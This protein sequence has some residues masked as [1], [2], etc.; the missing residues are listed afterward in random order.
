MLIY[1]PTFDLHHCI[2]RLLQ[3]MNNCTEKNEIEVERIRIWDFYLVFPNEILSLRFPSEALRYKSL[4]KKNDENPYEQLQNRQRVFQ[5]MESYQLS[6][7][8]CIASYGFIDSE[9]LNQGKVKINRKALPVE[10][11]E[12]MDDSTYRNTNIISLLTGPLAGLNLYGQDGLKARS[13]LLE[14]RYDNI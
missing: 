13:S 2:F 7:L 10:L 8:K 5:R 1:N 11:L 9:K 12:K 6:A 14:Y 4:F 3:L